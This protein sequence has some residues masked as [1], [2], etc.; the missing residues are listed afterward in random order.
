MV[1]TAAR[2]SLIAVRLGRKWRRGFHAAACQVDVDAALVLLGGIVETQS[3]TDLLDPRLQLL[4]VAR[5]V[6]PPADDDVQVGL[7]RVL[8]VADA[9]FEDLLGLLDV[10]AVEVDGVV[11]YAPWRV[12]LAE[13]ELGRLLVV[14]GLL[15]LV[16][17]A[18]EKRSGRFWAPVWPRQ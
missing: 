3:A 16:A 11:G 14:L 17:L 1:V 15:L 4:H 6:I 8:G 10:Q 5:R 13:D 9:G 18:W 7:P 2:C 12:V